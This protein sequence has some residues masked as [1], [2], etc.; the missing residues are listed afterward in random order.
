L[1]QVVARLVVL[2]LC[3]A[4]GQARAAA[5]R[6]ALL[7]RDPE[8]QRAL[9]V[10]LSAW[11]IETVPLDVPPPAASQPEAL[12]EATGLGRE[13]E[14]LGMV[15]LTET[16]TGSLL[17]VFETETRELTLRAIGE[18]P[19]FDGATA[20]GIA[21]SVKTT[22]RA[23]LLRHQPSAPPLPSPPPAP[24]TPTPP[25]RAPQAPPL[26]EEPP[27]VQ[28]QAALH[29]QL[30]ASE[31]LRAW[32]SLHSTIWLG[33]RRSAG[34]GLDLGAGSAV[35]VHGPT[36]AGSFRELAF[37][38]SADFRVLARPSWLLATAVGGTI[39]ASSLSGTLSRDGAAGEAARY[40]VSLDA[41]AWLDVRVGRG[42]CIGI[43]ARAAYFIGYQR[44]LVEGQTVFAPWRLVPSGGAHVGFELR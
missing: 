36:F 44:Y 8:L 14:L 10:A 1:R 16:E 4:C 19:P 43:G 26:P 28:T 32:F 11:N 42:V 9:S 38:P 17:W 34:I 6:V 31:A 18:R 21:L 29:A 37:G 24:P 5:P 12:A 13:L 3:L 40:S 30:R 23:E 27:R 22:L 25:R 35:S 33:V 39:H 41:A 7:S 2:V 15:W 20:A